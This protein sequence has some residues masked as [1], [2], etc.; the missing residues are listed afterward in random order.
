ML[1]FSDRLGLDKTLSAHG[2]TSRFHRKQTASI[3]GHAEI[4][5]SSGR[6]RL[7]LFQQSSLYDRKWVAAFVSQLHG[8]RDLPF[9]KM[10]HTVHRES[11]SKKI[12]KVFC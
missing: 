6:E 2:F 3:S 9:S 1:N 12:N 5:L 4:G 11:K 10:A 7:R 8:N